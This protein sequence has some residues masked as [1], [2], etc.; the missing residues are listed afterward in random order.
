MHWQA[1]LLR[2]DDAIVRDLAVDAGRLILMLKNPIDVSLISLRP[3]GLNGEWVELKMMLF[4]N[5]QPEGGS[6]SGQVV[7]A[8]DHAAYQSGHGA[9]VLG[10]LALDPHLALAVLAS[11]R[12]GRALFVHCSDGT[13]SSGFMLFDGGQLVQGSIYGWEGGDELWRF[14]PD[15]FRCDKIELGGVDEFNYYEP[16]ASGLTGLIGVGV[17]E[18]FLSGETVAGSGLRYQLMSKRQLVSPIQAVT[19]A[20]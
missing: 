13:C 7:A 16:V 17:D 18:L 3:T 2:G 12:A 5:R 19:E 8:F 6:P 10:L 9:E 20:N 14:A 4:L 11:R 15:S 1:V